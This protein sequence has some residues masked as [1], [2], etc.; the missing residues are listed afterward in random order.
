[1]VE[2]DDVIVVPLSGTKFIF[3]RTIDLFRVNT[4]I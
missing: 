3:D 4:A 2:E 1:M